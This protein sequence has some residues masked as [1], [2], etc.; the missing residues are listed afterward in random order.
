MR[1]SG[2]RVSLSPTRQ[3]EFGEQGPA[4]LEVAT[5]WLAEQPGV[6][7]VWTRAEMRDGSGPEPWAGLHHRSWAAGRDPDL[8][9]QGAEGCLLTSWAV[10]TSH[11]SPYAYDRRVPLIFWGAG[12][13]RG[14]VDTP[15]MTVDIAP[16]LAGLIGLEVPVAIDGRPLAL[17]HETSN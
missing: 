4:I 7:R 2:T 8:L 10:G 6:A 11:G 3:G 14:R 15:A 5:A 13:D 9:L 1:W 12:V 16:T 17:T